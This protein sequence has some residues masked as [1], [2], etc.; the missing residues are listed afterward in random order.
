M[1][2]HG[3]RFLDLGH[4]QR[5]AVGDRLDLDDVLRTLHE[6]EGDP[7]DVFLER[8]G[9]VGAI[10]V[11][12][13]RGRDRGVGETHA[14]LAPIPVPPPRRRSRRVQATRRQRAEAP[15]RRRSE[16]DGRA[17]ASSGSPDAAGRRASGPP[18]GR[19]ASR[20]NA[21]PLCRSAPPSGNAPSLSFGPCKSTRMPI[22]RPVSS[23]SEQI[24]ATRSRMRVMRGV[25]HVDRKTSAPAANRA[26]I[27]SRSA[28]AGPRVAMI[29]T[30]RRRRSCNGVPPDNSRQSPQLHLIAD[31]PDRRRYHEL[32]ERDTAL[33]TI[34]TLRDTS[35]SRCS[36]ARRRPANQVIDPSLRSR[37]LARID[38]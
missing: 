23:S 7:V 14:L 3:L 28:E 20:A 33:R 25:A 15:C 24:I 27:V 30:R 37:R 6:R 12:H 17:R 35:A 8:R 34:L 18:E 29:L 19:V 32:S 5:A 36:S 2:L 16:P 21:S 13:R 10:L 11:R 4:H 31:R 22:G 26:A 9:E 38:S 1:P